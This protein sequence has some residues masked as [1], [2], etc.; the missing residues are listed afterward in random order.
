MKKKVIAK[1]KSKSTNLY[2]IKP[3][4]FTPDD[5][6]VIDAN[7]EHYGTKNCAD[8]VR[9]MNRVMLMLNLSVEDVLKYNEL[10]EA[11]SPEALKIKF[12]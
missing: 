11:D 9:V 5:L 6:A 4:R 1:K 3:I 7:Q 2:P 12:G 8:T 10:Y